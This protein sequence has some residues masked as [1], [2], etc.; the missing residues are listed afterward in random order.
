V[1]RV[2]GIIMFCLGLAI[3]WQGKDLAVGNLRSPGSGFFPALIAVI[4]LILSVI[5]IIFPPSKK[6]GSQPEA[7]KAGEGPSVSTKSII[8]TA[9]VF[10]ALLLYAFFLEY[11]GFVIVS[12]LLT[13][14]LFRAFGTKS[15]V[16]SILQA[17]LSTGLSYGLFEVLLKSSLPRGILGF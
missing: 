12:F 14:L 13:T 11:A 2:Y 9:A 17:A 15:F 5:L 4:I 8:R 3:L 7:S 6:G 10:V 16:R 1:E